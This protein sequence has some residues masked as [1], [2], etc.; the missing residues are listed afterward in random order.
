M[1]NKPKING[2]K[3]HHNPN[4]ITKIK[5]PARIR[6]FHHVG[7][8]SGCGT[9][10]VIIPSLILN[11]YY[12]LKY[13]FESLYNTRYSP[14]PGSYSDCS[15]VTFQRSSTIQQLEMIKH[16][17]KS[18]PSRKI[19]YEID[20][21]L[22]NIPDWNF[23]SKFYNS[24][25]DNIKK[26]IGMCDGVVCSTNKLKHTLSPYNDNITVSP[27][28]LPKFIWGEAKAKPETNQSKVR[29]MYAGSHNHFDQNSDRGDFGPKLIEYVKKTIDDFQWIFVG[30]IPQSLKGNDRII[31][32]FWRPVIE[33]P[34]F[35]K[36]LNPDIF[37]APLDINEFNRSKSD[38]KALEAAALGIPLIATNIEP[39]HNMIHTASTEEYFISMLDNLARIDHSFRNGIWQTQYDALK[40]RLFWEDNEH[41]NLLEYVNKHLH[42]IGK[43]L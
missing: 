21:D 39:Y 13:Q 3:K 4:I 17:K 35:L 12:S 14:Y 15:Y 43:E 18:D 7:D 19:L 6:I 42:L 5:T 20:D 1:S 27:N 16:L 40:D 31:N 9:I 25:R 30:G 26:I 28:Y 33:Y 23:A 38:I 36:S 8:M 34:S 29:I 24:N 22:L 37:L 2:T 11:N 10:R 41:K 32:H